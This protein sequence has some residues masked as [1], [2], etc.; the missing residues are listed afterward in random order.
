MDEVLVGSREVRDSS[1]FHIRALH[2]HRQEELE[3]GGAYQ[4]IVRPEKSPPSITQPYIEDQSNY[5]HPRNV[6]LFQDLSE[7]NESPTSNQQNFQDDEDEL[8]ARM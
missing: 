5:V 7:F 2:M 1:Q 8:Q 6:E 4:E 3:I